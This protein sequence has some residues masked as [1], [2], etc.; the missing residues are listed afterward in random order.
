M[1][2]LRQP[3]RLSTIRDLKH[4]LGRVRVSIDVR[5]RCGQVQKPDC[6]DALAVELCCSDLLDNGR[7][8]AV[9][10]VAS[11]FVPVLL[12][13]QM[14]QQR[15]AGAAV[16]T[17]SALSAMSDPKGKSEARRHWSE[18]NSER[19]SAYTAFEAN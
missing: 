5:L 9:V 2:R 10:A 12:H 4:Q 16:R 15:C 3:E 19:Q 17:W 13:S 14:T 6:F 1:L 8:I 7:G 18:R 11:R